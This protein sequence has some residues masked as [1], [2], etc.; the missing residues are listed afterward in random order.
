MWPLFWE[1]DI[2]LFWCICR[3]SITKHKVKA[4]CPHDDP[5]FLKLFYD[6]STYDIRAPA[7][8]YAWNPMLGVAMNNWP[9]AKERPW[10][11]ES[12][13]ESV[14]EFDSICLFCCCKSSCDGPIKWIRGNCCRNNLIHVQVNHTFDLSNHTT[15]SCKIMAENLLKYTG[16]S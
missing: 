16:P 6:F 5:H 15:L 4:W 14:C 9:W 2:H 11:F 1:R 7:K 12:L 8:S 13:C 3:K 10:E